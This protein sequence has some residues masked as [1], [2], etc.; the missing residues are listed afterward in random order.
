MGLDII[1]HYGIGV[2]LTKKEHELNNILES[3]NLECDCFD[4]Y[5]YAMVKEKAKG[6][7]EYFAVGS[8]YDDEGVDIY[9]TIKDPFENGTD[10]LH[11]KFKMLKAFLNSDIEI[12]AYDNDIDI[13]GGALIY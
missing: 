3:R 8:R 1:G 12:F 6:K 5:I 7:I 10:G 4:S 11:A 9:I 13:V 2:K